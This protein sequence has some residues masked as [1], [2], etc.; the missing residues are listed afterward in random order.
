LIDAVRFSK[1]RFKEPP[2]IL[3]G[4]YFVRINDPDYAQAFGILQGVYTMLGYEYGGACNNELAPRYWFEQL[5]NECWNV[6]TFNK[7]HKFYE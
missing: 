2:T 4:R 7:E 5:C 3:D 6:E 1:I